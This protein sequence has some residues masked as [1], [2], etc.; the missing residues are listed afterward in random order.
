MWGGRGGG[1]R[2]EGGGDGGREEGRE[3]RGR[4]GGR[5]NGGEGHDSLSVVGYP[6]AFA[7][8]STLHLGSDA[9]SYGGWVQ[10]C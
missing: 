9:T 1:G 5:R 4:R 8:V 6:C 2:G 3:E 10:R 7:Q